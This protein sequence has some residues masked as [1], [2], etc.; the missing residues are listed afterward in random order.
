M[1]SVEFGRCMINMEGKNVV[2]V[3]D[4]LRGFMES[5]NNLY[6]GDD[7]RDIIPKVRDLLNVELGKSST[8]FYIC[9]NHRPDDLEF[10]IFPTHCLEG[11]DEANIITELDGYPGQRIN[12]QRYSGFYGTDLG[13][14]LEEISPDKIIICGVCTDICVLHTAADARNRDFKVEVLESTVAS[15]DKEAHRWALDHMRN[16]LGVNIIN[17]I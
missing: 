16:V 10:E 4:M 7:A 3:V 17:G 12:K 1:Q 2:L 14:R 13:K 11:T 6:C 8:I 9:D 5:G 15:F